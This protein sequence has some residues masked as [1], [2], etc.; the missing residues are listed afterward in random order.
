M[1]Q[2]LSTRSTL[3]SF[4]VACSFKGEQVRLLL[5][6]APFPLTTCKGMDKKLGSCS[7]DSFLSSYATQIKGT[8]GDAAWN[9]SC[10]AGF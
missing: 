5:N 6:E 4:S 9:A 1:F 2:H 7:L 8:W 3:F 10:G